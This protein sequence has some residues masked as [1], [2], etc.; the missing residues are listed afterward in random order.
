MSSGQEIRGLSLAVDRL[1]GLISI[2]ETSCPEFFAGK[3]LAVCIFAARSK[4]FSGEMFNNFSGFRRKVSDMDLEIW[5]DLNGWFMG[6]PLKE[7]FSGGLL[8]GFIPFLLF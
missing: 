8:I 2:M 4:T 1:G 5:I 7:V 6:F 3:E